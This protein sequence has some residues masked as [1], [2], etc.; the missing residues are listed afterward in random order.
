MRTLFRLVTLNAARVLFVG[1][2][3]LAL[4]AGLQWALTPDPRPDA[5]AIAREQAIREASE[6][7]AAA[8]P[9]VTPTPTA[10]AP[11]APVTPTPT[12]APPE[13]LIA[14]AKDPS[15]TTVQVLD[16]G[17]GPAAVDAAVAELESLGYD[18]I[19]VTS[20]S[21]D[22]TTTTVWWTADA[23]AEA[24]ALRARAPR[25]QEVGPNEGLSEGV[26]IHV[27]VGPGF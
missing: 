17:G 24:R 6:S 9:E 20:S 10:T 27:L 1:A 23:E 16:A 18:I 22:V 4:W 2:L 25:F 12:E 26:D 3:A 8:E 21:R 11:A 15:Q 7:E 13:E 5:E 19:N 14:A